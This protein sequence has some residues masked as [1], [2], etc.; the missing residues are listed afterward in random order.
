MISSDVNIL[1]I[2][3]PH[4]KVSGVPEHDKMCKSIIEKTKNKK[5]DLIVILGDILDR[6]ET[7]HVS[8]LTRSIKF[9]GELVKIAPIYVLIGNHDL[10]NN[11]QFLSEEHA[12]SSFKLLDELQTKNINNIINTISNSIDENLDI[13]NEI[14]EN[15]KKLNKITF[16]DKVMTTRISNQNFISR[17]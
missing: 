7:I 11:K 14:A 10:K 15:I 4:F 13:M 12:F 5:I 1:V 6:F 16:V 8:P 9:L 17:I 2:G 3:D